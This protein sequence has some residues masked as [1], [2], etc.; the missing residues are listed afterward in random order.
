MITAHPKYTSLDLVETVY[1]DAKT[2]FARNMSPFI[3]AKLSA[4]DGILRKTWTLTG[5]STWMITI[6][7]SPR[8]S[9]C[10]LAT[11]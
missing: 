8:A 4:D 6:N 10:L 3:D 2:A 11:L 7:S 5:G 9:M 1:K